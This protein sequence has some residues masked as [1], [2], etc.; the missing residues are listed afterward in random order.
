MKFYDTP[1]APNPRRVTIFMKEKGIEIPTVN[2]NLMEGEHRKPEYRA[3][4]PN[5]KVPALELDDGSVLLET[6]AICRYLESLYPEPN[7]MGVDG[8][9]AAFIEM[10]GRRIEFELFIPSAMAFRHLH[11][12]GAALEGQIKEYGEACKVAGQKR[13]AILDKDLGET[14]FIAGDRFTIADITTICSVDFAAMVS[15]IHIQDGQDNL[16]RWYEAVSNRPSVKA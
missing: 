2:V 8:R 13:Y 12:A 4:A 1:M 11:P 15:D 3:V 7:L 16:K 6:V 9:E 10:W 5:A 14:E